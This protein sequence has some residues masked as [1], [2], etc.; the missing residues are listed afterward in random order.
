MMA[1]ER[2]DGVTEGRPGNYVFFDRTMVEIGV[3]E[4]RDLGVTV[5]TTV[6]SHQPGSRQ[7]I[8]DAGALALSKDVGPTHLD[9]APAMGVVKDHAELTLVSL[10]QEHGIVHAKTAGEIAGRFK[11]GDTVEIIPN[12]SCLTVANFDRYHVM[13]GGKETA[14][15]TVARGRAS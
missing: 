14:S 9:L 6:V 4:L 15:W 13:E 3:C 7:F 1:L 11:V 12:H 2:G 5:L 8:V 10:S